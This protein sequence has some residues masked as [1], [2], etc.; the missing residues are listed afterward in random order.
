MRFPKFTTAILTFGTYLASAAGM[1]NISPQCESAIVAALTLSDAACLNPI[2]LAV[3]AATPPD[4]SIVPAVD[5]WLG[6]L[7]SLPPCTNQSLA[8]IFG[9]IASGCASELAVANITADQLVLAVQTVYP[10]ER[11]I[12]CL[13]DTVNNILCVTQT[14]LNLET[15]VGPLSLN[16]IGPAIDSV[17]FGNVTIPPSVICT[18]C[19]KATFSIFVTNLPALVPPDAAGALSNTCGAPFIDGTIPST[20]SQTAQ[21]PLSAKFRRTLSLL[22]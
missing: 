1:P 6:G 8:N 3:V 12:S 21:T 7:C 15:V 2:G 10:T 20:I 16:N 18:D 11:Q 22:I 4:V 19:N 5:S 13:K 14:L 17:V 9:T